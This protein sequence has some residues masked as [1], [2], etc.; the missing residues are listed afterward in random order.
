MNSNSRLKSYGSQKSTFSGF[1][2]A[3]SLSFLLTAIS[4][5]AAQADVEDI[6]RD[7]IRAEI[8][9]NR[10]K[11]RSLASRETAQN[12]TLSTQKN[13]GTNASG[14]AN[15]NETN[16]NTQRRSENNR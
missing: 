15:T 16:G 2:F 9:F 8:L 1:T 10:E 7:T 3:L 5:F 6:G 12:T 13:T 11:E 14:A 4:V